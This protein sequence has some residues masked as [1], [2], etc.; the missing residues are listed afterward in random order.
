M[1]LRKRT[2][3]G[4]NNIDD[5]KGHLKVILPEDQTKRVFPIDEGMIDESKIVSISQEVMYW[6]KA[7]AIH[8]WF[9]ENVQQGVDNCVEYFVS[10]EDLQQRITECKEDLEYLKSTKDIDEHKLN[11]TTTSGF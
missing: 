8:K 9:V 2:Y 1:Y 3:V 6:R 4:N 11:L 7:N 5:P 10:R